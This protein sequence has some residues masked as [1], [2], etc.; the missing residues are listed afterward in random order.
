[1]PNDTT[2]EWCKREGHSTLEEVLDFLDDFAE[3]LGSLGRY[4]SH[5]LSHDSYTNHTMGLKTRGGYMT[6]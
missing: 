3:A 4:E 6:N 1:M 5:H 2:Q